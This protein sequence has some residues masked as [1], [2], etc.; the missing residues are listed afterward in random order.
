MSL[1]ISINVEYSSDRWTRLLS[2]EWLWKESTS[3]SL[4]GK[5]ADFSDLSTLK[6]YH[7]AIKNKM[8]V[9]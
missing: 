8:K 6:R 5:R 3:E 4:V 2:N 9:K 7:Q 1:Y